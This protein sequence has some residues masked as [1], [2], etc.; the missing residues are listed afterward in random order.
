[1]IQ[2]HSCTSLIANA[3]VFILFQSAAIALTYRAVKDVTIFR[4]TRR[5]VQTEARIVKLE[6]QSEDRVATTDLPM[7]VTV[8]R[9]SV[10]YT[11]RVDGIQYYGSRAGP[12]ARF[13]S[14]QFCEWLN[15]RNITQCY[16]NTLNHA[17]SVLDIT[18]SPIRPSLC[19]A[20]AFFLVHFAFIGILNGFWFAVPSLRQG[21]HWI[22]ALFVSVH[23][24]VSGSV[25]TWLGVRSWTPINRESYIGVAI[26]VALV[27][28]SLAALFISV[29]SCCAAPQA[30]PN[31]DFVDDDLEKDNNSG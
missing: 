15:N 10:N 9:C 20:A 19:L 14:K 30:A 5:W 2:R 3:T 24:G 26:G 7:S 16:Y 22:T 25:L 12:L 29:R 11:Y 28:I 6:L 31:Y 13:G 18:F 17:D 27:L 1:M 21:V 23:A 4:Q 8:Y